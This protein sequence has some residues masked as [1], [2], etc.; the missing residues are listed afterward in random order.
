MEEERRA[1]PRPIRVV[2]RFSPALSALE[3][4]L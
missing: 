1:P 2:G 3:S 4:V